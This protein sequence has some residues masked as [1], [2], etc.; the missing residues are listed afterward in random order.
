MMIFYDSGK[1]MFEK[2]K[3]TGAEERS[4]NVPFWDHH[5]KT[6]GKPADCTFHRGRVG[7]EHQP[8]SP[9]GEVSGREGGRKLQALSQDTPHIHIH[10][11]RI[12][13]DE[14]LLAVRQQHK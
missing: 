1:E 5:L 2:E 9:A 8:M 6:S 13:A 10:L 4:P 11:A 3:V 12:C 14:R 7:S